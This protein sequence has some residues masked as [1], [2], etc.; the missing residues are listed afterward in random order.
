VFSITLE[1]I[2]V[3]RVTV[4]LT[5]ALGF[6]AVIAE[7]A[8]AQPPPPALLITVRGKGTRS[9]RIADPLTMKI[10]DSV[11]MGATRP[12][13]IAVSPDGK[14]ADVTVSK[15]G[16]EQQAGVSEE[17]SDDCIAVIDLMA[18]KELRRIVIGPGSWPFS[19]VVAP[20]KIYY[21]AERYGVVGRYDPARNQID[22]M[23]GTDQ[24]RTHTPVMSQD[25]EH[26]C[27]TN[28]FF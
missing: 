20:E 1:T 7:G 19:L 13:E 23:I 10:V 6:F 28:N 26:I 16:L 5:L 14:L 3:R 11:P 17:I 9:A 4:L 25:G 8:A 12:H 18:Q 2:L 22:R 27:S 21:T 24:M 15:M